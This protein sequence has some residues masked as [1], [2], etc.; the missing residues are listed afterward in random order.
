MYANSALTYLVSGV[1]NRHK[2]IKTQYIIIL[3]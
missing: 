1:Y 2:T 3:G